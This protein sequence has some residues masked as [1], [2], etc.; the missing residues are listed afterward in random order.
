MLKDLFEY[1]D[2]YPYAIDLI[3]WFIF[4][5]KEDDNYLYNNYKKHEH[6]LSLIALDYEYNYTGNLNDIENLVK[7]EIGLNDY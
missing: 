2:V 6:V 7:D 1:S 3:S 5:Y 4:G